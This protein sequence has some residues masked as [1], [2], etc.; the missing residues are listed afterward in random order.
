MK[1]LKILIIFLTIMIFSKESIS[2]SIHSTVLIKVADSLYIGIPI[3]QAY[4]IPKATEALKTY[5]LLYINEYEINKYK[6]EIIIAYSEIVGVQAKTVE[7]LKI[8]A[9]NK[10]AI[11]NEEK[12]KIKK[13]LEDKDKEIKKSK[14]KSVKKTSIGFIIGVGTGLI[15]SM[16]T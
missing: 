4:L 13:Q 12:E 15:L 16:F 14:F 3:E 11:E 6:D 9:A 1:I 2:Q 8:L 7:E 5:E 10:K